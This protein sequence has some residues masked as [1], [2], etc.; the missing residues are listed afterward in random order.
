MKERE[1]GEGER[2]RE[3]GGG[4]ERVFETCICLTAV[5]GQPEVTMAVDAMFKSSHY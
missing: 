4:Y 5:F 2:E 1:R 3:R